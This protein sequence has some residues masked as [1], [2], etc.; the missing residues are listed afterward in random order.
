MTSSAVLWMVCTGLKRMSMVSDPKL[1][2]EKIASMPASLVVTKP[3]LAT[4]DRPARPA[5]RQQAASERQE[6][7]REIRGGNIEAALGGLSLEPDDPE[8][9]HVLPSKPAATQ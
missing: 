8:F 9:G 1:P 5:S 6:V 7:M 3:A 4:G 2:C